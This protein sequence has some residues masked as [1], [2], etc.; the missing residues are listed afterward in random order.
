MMVSPS[1]RQAREHERRGGAQVR[2]L[3]ARARELRG[4]FDEGRAVA[5]DADARAHALH[6]GGVHEAVLEDRLDDAREPS[7][8]V[9][10]AMY[11]ACMSVGKSGYGSVVTSR[12]LS[13]SAS[14]G[15][16]AASS[17]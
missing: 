15:A 14:F 5:L 6:L 3:H 16:R 2:S 17:G 12:A 11:C 9:I 10:S 8:C 13:P 7:A 4:A 1:R